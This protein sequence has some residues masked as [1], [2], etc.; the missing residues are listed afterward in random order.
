MDY[1]H[2]WHDVVTGAFLGFF[3]SWFAYRQYY[4]S[5]SHPLSHRPYS[6]RISRIAASMPHVNDGIPSSR[7]GETDHLQLPPH[8]RYPDDQG[9]ME[10]RGHD[11]ASGAD[12]PANLRD[13][14]KQGEDPN[15]LPSGHA[16]GPSQYA[17]EQ[18]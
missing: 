12:H 11:P 15:I 1:R 7:H 8:A 3:L 4:P 10:L 17:D 16:K 5:L 18:A 6:P 9:D 14:W 13:V 2:H